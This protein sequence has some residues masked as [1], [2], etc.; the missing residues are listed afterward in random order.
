MSL[1]LFLY[2]GDSGEP[3][4]EREYCLDFFLAPEDLEMGDLERWRD[5]L[6]VLREPAFSTSE[7]R[8]RDREAGERDAADLDRDD[9]ETEREWGERDREFDRGERERDLDWEDFLPSFSLLLPLFPLSLSP[10][11][12]PV[13]TGRALEMN[14]P[15]ALCEPLLRSTM[16]TVGGVL[17]S[18]RSFFF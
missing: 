18:E 2:L 14:P 10:P 7:D 16:T 9:L 12:P 4:R 11:L 13:D 3:D 8:D 15:Q 1:E 5:F 6:L 17:V